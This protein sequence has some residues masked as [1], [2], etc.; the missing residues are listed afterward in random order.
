MGL[1]ADEF[2]VLVIEDN[3]AQRKLINKVLS[4]IEG[5]QTVLCSDA[6]EGFATLLTKHKVDLI[7]LDV[8]LPFVQG[9]ALI[10]KVRSLDQYADLPILLSTA[11][12]SLKSSA[13]SQA[14]GILTKPYDINQIRVFIEAFRT[15]T[16]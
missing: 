13:A 3:H 1:Y 11:E 4:K 12:S 15:P 10:Q 7:M 8:N 5:V 14:N 16:T 2:N 9:T 6:F